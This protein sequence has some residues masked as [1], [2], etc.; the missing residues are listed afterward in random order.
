MEFPILIGDL[1]EGGVINL[2]FVD[3][4]KRVEYSLDDFC[5]RVVIELN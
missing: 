5:F 2:C 1:M 4:I 3:I